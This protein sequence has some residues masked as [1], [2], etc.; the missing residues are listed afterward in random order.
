MADRDVGSGRA[1]ELCGC[2][3]AKLTCPRLKIARLLGW[4]SSD[5]Q[6]DPQ[7]FTKELAMA[8][9]LVALGA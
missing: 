1:S 4:R 6:L 7:L 3:V 9:V 5:R 2:L 8:L